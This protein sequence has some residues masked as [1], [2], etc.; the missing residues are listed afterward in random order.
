MAEKRVEDLP[1]DTLETLD[2]ER[3][4]LM[5]NEDEGRSASLADISKYALSHLH[6]TDNDGDIVISVR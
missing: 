4:F 6:F 1:R 5:F 3:R 2:E